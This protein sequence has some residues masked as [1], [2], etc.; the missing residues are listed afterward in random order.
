MAFLQ[1]DPTFKQG[2]NFESRY[3]DMKDYFRIQEFYT[4]LGERNKQ[5]FTSNDPDIVEIN[6]KR[7]T[8]SEDCL[9]H[10]SWNKYL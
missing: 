3:L 8:L 6:G 2:R 5:V 10:I 9:R 4:T 1:G 7:L